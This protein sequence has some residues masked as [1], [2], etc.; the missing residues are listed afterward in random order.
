MSKYNAA[1]KVL[2]KATHNYEVVY[3]QNMME[4]YGY[5]KSMLKGFTQNPQSAKFR[6]ASEVDFARF[7]GLFLK[8]R[9]LVLPPDF[10]MECVD[11]DFL[12]SQL[13]KVSET[14]LSWSL[15]ILLSDLFDDV[16]NESGISQLDIVMRLAAII[17]QLEAS[18]G[19]YSLEY[20]LGMIRGVYLTISHVDRDE[21]L[22]ILTD[23]VIEQFFSEEP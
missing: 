12:L 8:N 19:K 6:Q 15:S 7:A 14:G 21:K 1:I 16:E 11:V 3:Y 9:G 13:S 10:D 2:F 20:Y 23:Q 5:T 18:E 22:R 4:T 17:D